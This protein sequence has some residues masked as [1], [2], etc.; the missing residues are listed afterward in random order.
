[1]HGCANGANIYVAKLCSLMRMGGLK[2]VTMAQWPHYRR[3][4]HSHH[5]FTRIYEYMYHSLHIHAKLFSLCS[6]AAKLNFLFLN[7]GLTSAAA[8][9]V[10]ILGCVRFCVLAR[11]ARKSG[12]RPTGLYCTRSAARQYQ[13]LPSNCC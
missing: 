12:G 4:C 11:K 13:F 10:Q 2:V 7:Y 3:Q 1:M 8:T 6:L 9:N 5:C